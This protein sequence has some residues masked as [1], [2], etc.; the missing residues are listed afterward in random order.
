MSKYSYYCEFYQKTGRLPE[1]KE[2]AEYIL[3][4]RIKRR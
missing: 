4:G 2:L 3:F 1:E